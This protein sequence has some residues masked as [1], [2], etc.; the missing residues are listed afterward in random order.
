MA[1]PGEW[2]GAA[3]E[4]CLEVV[5]PEVVLWRLPIISRTGEIRVLRDST[6]N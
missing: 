2:P 3:Y 6:A 5:S 1:A 4:C